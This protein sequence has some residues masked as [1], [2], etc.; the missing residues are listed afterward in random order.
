MGTPWT[1]A[2]LAAT[3]CIACTDIKPADPDEPETGAADAAGEPDQ[4]ESP[5][6]VVPRPDGGAVATGDVDA[7]APQAADGVRPTIR[8]TYTLDEEWV[9]IEWDI[10]ADV[11]EYSQFAVTDEGPFAYRLASG[12]AD[13]G[14]FL[15]DYFHRDVICSQFPDAASASGPH[16]IWVQIWP[17][18]DSARAESADTPGTITCP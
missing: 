11:T 1:Q 13:R 9:Y 4:E 16:E 10:V 2:A 12:A 17:G 8:S 3:L 14:D 5:P 6:S 7:G 15:Y 18:E